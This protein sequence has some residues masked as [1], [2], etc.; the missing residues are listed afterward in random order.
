MESYS[1][2]VDNISPPGAW[3]NEMKAA[4]WGYGQN[5]FKKVEDALA[6]VRIR[7][8]WQE[9]SILSLEINALRAEIHRLQNTK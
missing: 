2:T 8:L 3:D 7:G 4:P 9:A 5:Q 1:M 6:S